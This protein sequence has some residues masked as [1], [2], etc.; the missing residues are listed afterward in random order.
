MGRETGMDLKRDG[1]R[2]LNVIKIHCVNQKQ[3][4]LSPPPPPQKKTLAALAE[5]VSCPMWVLV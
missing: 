4:I 3:I 2:E 1:R 5:I